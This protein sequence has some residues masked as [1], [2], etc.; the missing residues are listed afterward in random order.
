[1][2]KSG[3]IK[4]LL[5]DFRTI[6]LSEARKYNLNQRFDA[7]FLLPLP[8][9]TQEI[10]NLKSFFLLQ[11]N[12]NGQSLSTYETDYWDTEEMQFFGD[13]AKGRNKRLKV[14][15]RFYT[16]TGDCF[17]EIKKKVKGK[18]DKIRQSSSLPQGVFTNEDKLFLRENNIDPDTLKKTLSVIYNRIT[19]WSTD[20]EGRI[21]I[22][23][24]LQ[25]SDEKERDK[26]D[27]VGIIEIKGSRHFHT[28][29]LKLFETPLLRYKTPMSKY[30]NGV[31]HLKEFD[32]TKSKLLHPVYKNL[33]KTN[34]IEQ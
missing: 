3:I 25:V 32:A 30:A 13:H 24:D 23:L 22:D 14:R 5:S 26:F 7:K 18:T 31:I 9:L 28:Q 27:H 11:I 34:N 21:T 16:D 12:E 1:L 8:I 20:R 6:T 15:K 4:E 19:L 33:L 17:I 29:M 10:K 2:E